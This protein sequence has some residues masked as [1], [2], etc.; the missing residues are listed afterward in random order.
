MDYREIARIFHG[1]GYRLAHQHLEG[2]AGGE[3]LMEAVGALYDSMDQLLD[4]FLSRAEREGNPADCRIGCSWCCHQPVFAGTHEILYLMDRIRRG[5]S[6]T[7]AGRWL[8]RAMEKWDRVRSL[9]GKERATVRYAC[10]FLES[11]HCS[12]YR[13][14]PMACRIYLSSSVAACRNHFENPGDER[15][16]PGLFEFPL[17][18]GRM[19]NQGFIAWLRQNGRMVSEWPLEQGFTE[20]WRAGETAGSWISKLY[21]DSDV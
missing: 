6:A 2:R 12:V 15:I 1:D 14:R 19:M 5:Y 4:S 8:E 10:P 21:N 16:F 3:A 18:S 11:D 13:E 7:D 9:S 17:R 20:F